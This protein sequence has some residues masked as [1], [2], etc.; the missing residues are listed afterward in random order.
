MG[1]SMEVGQAQ[2][3][4]EAHQKRIE[5]HLRACVMV[6]ADCIK[7]SS[8]MIYVLRFATG[9]LYGLKISDKSILGKSSGALKSELSMFGQSM[10]R[11]CRKCRAQR[12]NVKRRLQC[13]S[14]V[15]ECR[16]LKVR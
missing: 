14:A 10:R 3:N 8:L 13:Q 7:Y 15:Q 5:A 4:Y 12:S 6:L 11:E 16:E 9:L 2:L 1:L